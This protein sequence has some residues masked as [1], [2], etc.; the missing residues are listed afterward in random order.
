VV[1]VPRGH[2]CRRYELRLD[3]DRLR[4]GNWFRDLRLS[5]ALR[6]VLQEKIDR[7]LVLFL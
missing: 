7:I 6:P 3:Q 4:L 5:S 1:Q 2:R